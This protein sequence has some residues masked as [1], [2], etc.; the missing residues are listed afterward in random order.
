MRPFVRMVTAK[1]TGRDFVPKTMERKMIAEFVGRR[2]DAPRLASVLRSA[3][4]GD[5]NYG[6]CREG[7]ICLSEL[8]KTKGAFVH[9]YRDMKRIRLMLLVYLK[10]NRIVG[11]R[12]LKYKTLL[13]KDGVLSG[14]EMTPSVIDLGKAY[15]VL[16]FVTEEEKRD[17][18]ESD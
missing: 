9:T 6:D 1:P 17:C 11:A 15:R 13:Y 3:R 8:R 4:P 16:K 10:D 5:G 7:L 18:Y 12:I 14:Y 2:L